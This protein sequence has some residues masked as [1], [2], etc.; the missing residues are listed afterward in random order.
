MLL[1]L[2][3]CLPLHWGAE[4]PSSGELQVLVS[5]ESLDATF[6]TEGAGWQGQGQAGGTIPSWILL[7]FFHLQA[8]RAR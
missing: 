5:G 6:G 8:D 1:A 3:A 2:A 4:S 7:A